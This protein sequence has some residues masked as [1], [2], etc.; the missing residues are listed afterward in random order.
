MSQYANMLRK[1]YAQEM[2]TIRKVLKE[3]QIMDFS[4]SKSIKDLLHLDQQ[5]LQEK[6]RAL[7]QLVLNS[8]NQLKTIYEARQDLLKIWARS[9]LTQEQLLQDL[10][11]WCVRAEA[12]GIQAMK[13]FSSRLR[14]Y[15]L[16]PQML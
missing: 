8:S 4:S 14:S 11:V 1:A 10:E 16:V 3:Q 12:S 9:T 2:Q 13:E 7:L 5:S 15:Q 6:Q